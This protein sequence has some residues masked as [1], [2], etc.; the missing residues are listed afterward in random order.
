MK[1]L[2][3]F[4][5]LILALVVLVYILFHF[6]IDLNPDH[7]KL[8]AEYAA[9]G[10]DLRIGEAEYNGRSY[11]YLETGTD[12]SGTKPVLLLVHGAPGVGSM[13]QRFLQDEELRAKTTLVSPDRLGY[14]SAAVGGAEP[15]LAIQAAQLHDLLARYR[16]RRV[17]AVGH[18]FG[19]PIIV[20]Q[21]ID[22]PDD[23]DQLVLL[24]PALDPDHEKFEGLA[25][26]AR[27][28][29]TRWYFPDMV[30][31]SADEKLA[32]ADELRK[33]QPLIGDITVLT[34]HVH[35]DSDRIVPYENLAFSQK[36]F[37]DSILTSHT[38]P[39]SDHFLVEGAD[40]LRV[41]ELLLEVL[42]TRHHE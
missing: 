24:A 1:W 34:L 36:H 33:M 32:H 7:Q 4:G 25:K 18:S 15:S 40:F 3:R 21:A 14:G 30:R 39:G 42:D 9:L 31:V 20:R 37:Q 41:K 2:K 16:G 12:T 27:W 22:F 13:Y 23:L 35:G 11:A 19:G 38:L 26:I 17:I 10:I 6:V 28:K 8:Q 5:Y 29:L